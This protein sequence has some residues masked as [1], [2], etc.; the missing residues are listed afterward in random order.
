MITSSTLNIGE[1]VD[2]SSYRSRNII[3]LLR[4]MPILPM[5]L[6]NGAEGIGTGW[7]TFIPNFNPRDIV[8]NLR[9]LL[10]GEEQQPMSPWYKNFKGTIEE[11]P[12]KT[13]GKSYAC[14]GIA[15]KVTDMGGTTSRV[16]DP[17]S[18][19]YK[20]LECTNEEQQGRMRID[21]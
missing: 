19:W 4:Y 20:S 15:S 21:E 13:G 14:H 12:S 9:R 8:A 17:M 6:V 10:N 16:T 18:V 5:V 11:V 2:I 1:N 7:S 3:L